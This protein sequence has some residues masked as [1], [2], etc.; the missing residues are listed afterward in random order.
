MGRRR[1]GRSTAG[2]PT[3]IAARVEPSVGTTD[4]D[5]VQIG[6]RFM[7]GLGGAQC[8]EVKGAAPN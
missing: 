2:G 1:G 8:R 3:F 7:H 6:E 4:R 5:P